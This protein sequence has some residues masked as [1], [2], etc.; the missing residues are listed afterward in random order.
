[1]TG[2]PAA[3]PDHRPWTGNL[4]VSELAAVRAVG[5]APVGFVVGASV[6]RYGTQVAARR[7]AYKPRYGITGSQKLES[8]RTYPQ[9]VPLRYPRARRGG[10]QKTYQCHHVA[11]G[12]VPG[13][14]YEDA[15]FSRSV[16]ESF[17]R[18]RERLRDETARLGGHGV[19]AVRMEIRHPS[20]LA[21]ASPVSE[22]RLTG[23]AVRVDGSADLSRPFTSHLSGQEFA[24]LMR[25]G[26]IPVD[27]VIGMGAVRSFFGCVGSPADP[28]G[29]KEFT[30]RADAMQVCRELAIERAATVARADKA[31]RIIGAEPV[32]PF[33]TRHVVDTL[34]WSALVATAAIRFQAS[35]V[36]APRIMLT[37]GAS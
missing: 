23:T 17:D 13:F 36:E 30:Q 1:M 24:T 33:G 14:N 26:W 28:F 32:G 20:P 31:T 6:Y 27:T 18:A 21:A 35:T 34:F 15:D 25:S 7:L 22:I 4:S 10:Y 8:F 16:A 3:P 12:H 29:R 19:V 2:D 9:R 11:G 5:F 37:L